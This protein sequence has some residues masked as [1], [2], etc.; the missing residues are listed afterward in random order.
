MQVL[1]VLK[2]MLN[3][4]YFRDRTTAFTNGVFLD[5]THVHWCS[6][7]L[8][9]A[10][11]QTYGV[12]SV[13]LP[14]HVIALMFKDRLE[15]GYITI[16]RHFAL[17]VNNDASMRVLVHQGNGYVAVHDGVHDAVAK[18]LAGNSTGVDDQQQAQNTALLH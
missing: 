5:E 10:L 6:V 18:L 12:M 7:N 3:D 11:S 17:D 4:P 1:Q 2:S 15:E 8:G 9:A 14:N 16:S 13:L